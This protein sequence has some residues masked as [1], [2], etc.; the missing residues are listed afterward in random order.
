MDLLVKSF[1]NGVFS[2]KWIGD[3]IKI[4]EE[5][6]IVKQF[7]ISDIVFNQERMEAY[8]MLEHGFQLGIME[9]RNIEEE[10]FDRAFASVVRY[11]SEPFISRMV[12]LK[13][14]RELFSI[15]PETLSAS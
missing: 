5:S 11:G 6:S 7:D 13:K 12:K 14:D 8:F 10:E 15:K 3:R 4:V 9:F 2:A 1:G